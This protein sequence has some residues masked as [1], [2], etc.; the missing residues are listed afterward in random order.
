MSSESSHGRGVCG[1]DRGEL[2]LVIDNSGEATL[3][4]L[5]L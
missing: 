3:R 5:A 4:W 1:M 2:L